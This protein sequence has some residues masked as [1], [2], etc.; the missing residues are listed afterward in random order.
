MLAKSKADCG[1]MLGTIELRVKM[2]KIDTILAE[3][4]NAFRGGV[5]EP[6]EVEEALTIGIT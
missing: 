1:L 4:N 5:R 2:L 6:W 3:K